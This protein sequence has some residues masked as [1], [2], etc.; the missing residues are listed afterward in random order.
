MLAT[1][2]EVLGLMAEYTTRVI[3]RPLSLWVDLAQNQDAELD[4]A[5][6]AGAML[7]K[8]ADRGSWEVG[9]AYQ[10]IEKDALFAQL[11]DSDFAGGVS[12][13]AGWILRG[14]YALQKNWVMNLTLFDT[15]ET[16]GGTIQ[17]IQRFTP[18]AYGG[19]RGPPNVQSYATVTIR[20]DRALDPARYAEPVHVRIDRLQIFSPKPALP[21]S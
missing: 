11:I 1:Q 13:S 21:Q 4:T 9:L 17:S 16:V 2:L 14:G 5:F 7:G 10:V 20:P 19:D 18:V 12:D 8:A 6:G 15:G 3:E